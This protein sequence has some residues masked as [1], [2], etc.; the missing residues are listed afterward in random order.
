MAPRL[1]LFIRRKSLDPLSDPSLV[2]WVLGSSWCMVMPGLRHYLPGWRN[3]N[4]WVNPMRASHKSNRM[5]IQAYGGHTN[6]SVAAIKFWQN[7]SHH[8]STFSLNST[9]IVF[10]FIKQCGILLFLTQLACP[11][12]YMYISISVS[13]VLGLEDRF[14]IDSGGDGL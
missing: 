6:Y 11:Y 10:I 1:P 8:C 13:P 7:K 5:Y 9:L 4:H 14:L 12:Q 2:Q 3:W